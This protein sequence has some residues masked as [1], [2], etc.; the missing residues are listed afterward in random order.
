MECGVRKWERRGIGG[1]DGG[2]EPKLQH[3]AEFCGLGGRVGQVLGLYEMR[4]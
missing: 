4:E 3:I 2:M 1:K